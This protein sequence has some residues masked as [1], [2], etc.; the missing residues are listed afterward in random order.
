MVF[1]SLIIGLVLAFILPPKYQIE[2]KL[3]PPLSQAPSLFS[4]LGGV[5][6][7]LTSNLFQFNIPG[8]S[9][10]SS[11]MDILEDI[12]RSRTITEHIVDKLNLTKRFK[13]S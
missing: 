1:I 7:R 12:C 6:N 8:I 5:E 4:A 13:K 3:I 9:S 10:Q 11:I 2:A